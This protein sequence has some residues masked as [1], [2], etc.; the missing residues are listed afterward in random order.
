[1]MPYHRPMKN[2]IWI[3]IIALLL[4]SSCATFHVS[5]PGKAKYTNHHGRS[6]SK[7]SH[8][9]SDFE[10]KTEIESSFDQSQIQKEEVKQPQKKK[11]FQQDMQAFFWTWLILS[12]VT[13]GLFIC[14]MVFG[15]GPL[16]LIPIAIVGGF[17]WGINVLI[18]LAL[19]ISAI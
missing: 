9:Q 7:R 18:L 3:S 16:A 5:N 12:I 17:I 4:F 10:K 15:W 11:G 14:A 19:L 2:Y 13:L 1:M 8:D 6:L